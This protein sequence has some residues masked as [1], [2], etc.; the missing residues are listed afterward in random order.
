LQFVVISPP[1]ST[2]TQLIYFA[3]QCIWSVCRVTL[4]AFDTE[5]LFYNRENN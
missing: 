1:N 4:S 2:L 3:N 5:P